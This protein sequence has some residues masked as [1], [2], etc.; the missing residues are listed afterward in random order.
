MTKFRNGSLARFVIALLL[1]AV[2]FVGVRASAQE[3]DPLPIP[4]DTV[5]FPNTTAG[6]FSPATGFSILDS[7]MGS[8]NIS[9]YGLFRYI[10]QMPAGQTFTDHLGN[11]LEVKPVNDLN[12]HRSMIW[13]SGW[14]YDPRIRYTITSWSLPTTQQALVFGNIMFLAK[15]WLNFGTGIAPN[16]TAR[17]MQGSWPFWPG[18]DR[19]MSE[20]LFRGGFSSGFWITGEA[21]PRFTYTL[22]VNNNISQLGIVQSNDSR[23]LAWSG[24]VRWQPTTGEFGPRNGFGDLEYHRQVATQFGAS[25]GFAR[26]GRGAPRDQPPNATQ[27]KLSDGTNPF[28][29]GALAKDV[30]L[31]TLSYHEAAMDAGVKY[32][33][34]SFN[35]EYYW[36]TL[37]NFDAS[38]PLPLSS[39][40]DRGIMARTSYV[41]VPKTVDAFIFGDY[42]WDQFKRFPW[43]IGG[44]ASYYPSHT[45][46]L[47][48][49]AYILH[50]NKSAASSTFGY[51]LAGQT[52]TTF[53]L[54]VDILL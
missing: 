26:E 43:D 20:E 38:G 25:A 48:L 4:K 16:L 50:I 46:S 17:S 5:K 35:T 22:S 40:F 54:G 18:S 52:G 28:T 47:R 19:Q 21:L 41:V 13:L 51:Y 6:E 36:R 9:V 11:V 24:S 49:N 14:F 45:R 37:N 15:P 53:S 33:G 29:E 34:F 42:V 30:I 32:K 10:N 1:L 44:G 8:L 39:I 31:D 27:V 23:H 2:N 12:W 3:A 7:K